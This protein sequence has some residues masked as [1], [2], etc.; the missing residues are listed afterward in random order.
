M[1]DAPPRSARRGTRRRLL[2]AALVGLPASAV[3]RHLPS[4][5]AANESLL[6]LGAQDVVARIRKGEITA[7]AYV[8]AL[9]KQNAAH[10]HLNAVLAFDEGRVLQD[11]H[12]VDQFRAK[13]GKLGPLAGLPFAVKDQMDIAGYPTTG[14]HAFLKGY[15]AKKTAKV[16]DAMLQA[17][18]L[19][20]AK[21]NLGMGGFIITAVTNTNPHYGSVR[22]PYDP[23]RI[24]GGSS[25]GNGA[26]LA[27]RIV[28]ATLGE[29][30]GGSI[31]MPPAFCGIAGYRPSTFTLTNA[32]QGTARKHY[33][34][35]GMV[36]PA[37]LLETWGPMART[38]VDVAFLDEVISGARSTPANL[39]NVRLGIPPASYWD[40]DIVEPGVAKVMQEAFA[41]L[42]D[43]G[44][45]LV[46]VDFQ[47]LLDINKDDRLGVEVNRLP[48]RTFR[49][50]IAETGMNVPPEDMRRYQDSFPPAV[51]GDVSWHAPVPVISPEAAKAMFTAAVAA[52]ADFFR[53]NRIAAMAFPT[54][55]ITA[56]LINENG[57]TPGQKIRVKGKWLDEVATLLSNVIMG[58][59]FGAPGISLPAGL[60]NGLPVGFGLDAL[61]GGDQLVL[62]LGLA[63]EKVLG[64]LPAPNLK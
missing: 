39:K 25:G 18:A 49:D 61:P 20:F 37:G 58:P 56:P 43:A 13:G 2:K 6:D 24:P 59:R 54:I 7:E 38:M 3:V 23:A 11:A 9:I 52:H 57:D 53:G 41:K 17:G 62:G 15:M 35:D 19:L 14:G 42:R 64:P 32:L 47:G 29:D 50:W 45:V 8:T 46:E 63:I 51:R 60:S 40:S 1:K 16:A 30:T 31:R 10:S 44:A 34:D 4:A 28:P 33:S 12:A 36:P 27:A 55:P 21:T 48:K 26:V 22:N 5:E